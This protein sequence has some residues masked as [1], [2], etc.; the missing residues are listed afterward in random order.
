MARASTVREK[1]AETARTVAR[2]CIG[3]RIRLLSRKTTRIYDE[4]LRPHGLK[5]SQMNILTVVSFRGPIQPS[6][7]GQILSMEKSTLSRNVQRMEANGWLETLSGESG[8]A[9]LLRVTSQGGRLYREATPAWR[10]AQKEVTV[11][12]GAETVGAIREAVE[13]I[14]SAEG[15]A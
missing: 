10:R 8:N 7:V 6:R 12:L 13:R 4:R 3:A 11:L 2:E 5:F 15:T 14:R 9:R 1:A